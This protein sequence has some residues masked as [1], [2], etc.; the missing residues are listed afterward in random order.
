MSSVSDRTAL[1]RSD[2]RW[3]LAL[4]LAGEVLADLKSAYDQ[5]DR[6]RTLIAAH[7]SAKTYGQEM[8]KVIEARVKLLQVIRALNFDSRGQPAAPA[9]THVERME[10]YLHDLVGEFEQHYK[11]VS[12]EQS[13]YE[14]RMKSALAAP[15]TQA[16]DLP[17]NTPWMQI[18]AL[19]RINDFLRRSRHGETPSDAGRS[20]Y[21]SVFL[22]ALDDASSAL[23]NALAAELR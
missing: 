16:Q 14:A 22:T 8:Q 2:L 4:L 9:L 3:M 10:G 13:V 12:R 15:N 20:N 21:D 17:A 6:A 18:M 23:R 5:I 11:D 1:S 19:P 7:Q